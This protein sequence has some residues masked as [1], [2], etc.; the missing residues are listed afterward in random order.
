MLVYTPDRFCDVSGASCAEASAALMFTANGCT[1]L[2][3]AFCTHAT[4][5]LYTLA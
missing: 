2:P 5:S 3:E 4:L 1:Q